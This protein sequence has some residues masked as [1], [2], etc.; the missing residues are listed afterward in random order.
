MQATVLAI[1]GSDPTGGAG[2]Q[3]DLKTLTAIGVYGAAAITCVTVQ[4]SHSVV[5]VECLPADLV[6]DQIRIVLNDH[7]VTHVK[8]G[9]VGSHEIGHAI[10]AALSGFQGEIIYDPVMV[11]S[12]G[13]ALTESGTV[14]DLP[15]ILANQCTVLTPNVPELELLARATINTDTDIRHS[16]RKMF[17]RHQNLRAVLV[18]GG[19]VIRKNK[20]TDSLAYISKDGLRFEIISHPAIDTENIHGTGCTLASAFAAFHSLTGNYH[21]SFRESV[22]YMQAI[23]ENSKNVQVTRNRQGQ[24]CM[25]HSS[26]PVPHSDNNPKQ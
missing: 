12:T 14:A 25:L 20:I 13:H 3:A 17:D 9:M 16:T 24:G 4:N 5:R 6:H 19:H 21:I 8:I 23:L 7:R 10:T 22:K 18:K 1:A 26:S 2:I 11:S 15:A